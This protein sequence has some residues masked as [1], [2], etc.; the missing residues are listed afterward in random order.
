MV[1][2]KLTDKV[3]EID[4]VISNAKKFPENLTFGV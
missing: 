3:I 1:K 2:N 4:E